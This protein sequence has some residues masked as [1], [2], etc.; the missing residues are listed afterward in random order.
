MAIIRSALEAIGSYRFE[1][2]EF[3]TED[4]IA[5]IHDRSYIRYL[6]DTAAELRRARGNTPR[7]QWPTVFP[8][9]PNASSLPAGGRALRGKYCFDTYTPI[10]GGTFAAAMSGASAALRAAELVGGGVERSVFVLTRPPGHHAERDRSGGYCY[11]NNASLAAERLA[12]L[13]RVAVL[14]ID[15]HH[16]NG[17]QH[18]FYDRS[19]VLTI[20]LHGDPATLYPFFSGYT[21]ETGTGMGIGANRNFPLPPATGPKEFRIAL[22]AA[23]EVVQRFQPAFLVL[24]FG[25]DT[26][27]DD[28]IGG[29][30]LPTPFFRAMGMKIGELNLPTVITQEGGY[31]LDVIGGCVVEFL[32]GLAMNE[33]KVVGQE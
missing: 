3:V 15:A 33:T 30:K 10:L 31:H 29:F 1:E 20:S 24:A 26:H 23:L 7:M 25:A 11:F 12:K 2:A 27:E 28:P 19:D 8:Y 16:G 22:D 9:G 13:G 14:D 4:E 32:Q 18:I 21:H 6:S 5:A 17:T